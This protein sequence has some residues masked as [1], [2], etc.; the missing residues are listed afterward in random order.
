[1]MKRL[2]LGGLSVCLCACEA[3]PKAPQATPKSVVKSGQK[4]SQGAKSGIT[5]GKPKAT[6]AQKAGQTTERTGAQKV[7]AKST[8][9]IQKKKKVRGKPIKWESKIKWMSWEEGRAA[10]A[11]QGKALFL[12]VYTNWCPRCRELGPVFRDRSVEA[13]SKE[14]IMVRQNQDEG[15]QWL[16]AFTA[17]GRYVP[18][19]LFFGTD[20]QLR[21][22]LTS[23]NQRFP[24]FYTPRSTSVLAAN[25]KKALGK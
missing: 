22:D 5:K 17:Q 25:M 16:S 11:A 9:A 1:M 19:I 4:G 3:T 13:L 23:G 8:P 2:L 10:S 18:R 20:G 24:Y 12:I 14:M 15:P 21:T 7:A 6:L